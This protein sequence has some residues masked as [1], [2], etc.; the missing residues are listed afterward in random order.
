M[1][2]D[3]YDGPLPKAFDE[4]D[5]VPAIPHLSFRRMSD[6]QGHTLGHY[7]IGM[8][9]GKGRHG[10]VF[11]AQDLKSGRP[12]ALKVLS[13]DFPSN[14]DELKKF[15]RVIKA[16]RLIEQHPHIVQWYG[17]GKIGSYVW[18]AQE[19]IG[20]GDSLKSIFTQPES[21]RWSWRNAW[22]LAWELGNALDHLHRQHVPH[23]NIA[24]SNI[25]IDNEGKTKLNDLRF[26]EAIDGSA[27]QNQMMEAKLLAELHYCAPERLEENTFVDEYMADI[28]ALGVATY[29]RLSCGSLPLTGV[30]PRSTIN[31][32]LAGVNEKHRRN[33]PSA[34][35]NFL[36]VVYK[37]LARQQQDRYQT[38]TEL[39]ADLERFREKK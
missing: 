39:L 6:L 2:L 38:T 4:T 14:V 15:A 30:D 24:A 18:I 17:A 12:V 31:A 7:E 26:R 16:T 23:G 36:D 5:E 21:A 9:L 37:M 3:P 13:P 34:P 19:Q 20:N 28:Y 25:L 29:F 8:V 1:R 33:A 11:C 27:L 10:I 32:I 22:R 35:D